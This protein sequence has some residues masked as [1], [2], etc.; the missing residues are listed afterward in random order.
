MKF[1][2]GDKVV[3]VKDAEQT[4]STFRDSGIEFGTIAEIRG[5]ESSSRRG[6]DYWTIID[7]REIGVAEEEIER[8][9][10]HDVNPVYHDSKKEYVCPIC[11]G[12]S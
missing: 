11:I 9:C 7:G 6:F 2:V 10:H 3:V 8:P 12:E 4:P 5:K 1:E